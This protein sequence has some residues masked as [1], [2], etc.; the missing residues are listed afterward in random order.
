M[1]DFD[2]TRDL[3]IELSVASAAEGYDFTVEELVEGKGYVLPRGFVHTGGGVVSYL[4]DDGRARTLNAAA[5]RVYPATMSAVTGCTGSGFV[6]FFAR[7]EDVGGLLSSNDEARIAAAY[8]TRAWAIGRFDTDA[9]ESPPISTLVRGRNVASAVWNPAGEFCT[10][11]F[12][13]PMPDAN[14]VP[15]LT[16]INNTG[17]PISIAEWVDGSIAAEGFSVRFYDPDNLPVATSFAFE[18]KLG[19]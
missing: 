7:P 19:E 9:G 15:S 10:I 5:G 6:Q 13:T 8:D 11:T 12:E 17:N 4:D 18:V 2:P 16:A 14:Y 3:T 1:R